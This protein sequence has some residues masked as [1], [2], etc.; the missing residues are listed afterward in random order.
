MLSFFLAVS[1]AIGLV[2]CELVFSEAWSITILMI[3]ISFGNIAK[4]VFVIAYSNMYTLGGPS[5]T[6]S[7]MAKLHDHFGGDSAPWKA[8][9]RSQIL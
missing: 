6:F 3:V 2:C 7:K 1:V 4:L 5:A 8:L 9:A